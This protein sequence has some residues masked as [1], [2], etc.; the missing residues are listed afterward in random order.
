VVDDGVGFD[1]GCVEPP[2]VA[3]GG[4]GLF[5]IRERLRLLGGVMEIES[6]A[7]RG[8]RVVLTAPLDS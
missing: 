3:R 4:F 5:S 8:T 1:P 7:G 6:K 2:S